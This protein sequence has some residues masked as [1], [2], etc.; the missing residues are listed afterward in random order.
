MRKLVTLI[1]LSILLTGCASANYAK[2]QILSKDETGYSFDTAPAP[3]NWLAS[4]DDWI[5]RH[6]W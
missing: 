6:L 4:T 3:S 5:S 1:A 2:N